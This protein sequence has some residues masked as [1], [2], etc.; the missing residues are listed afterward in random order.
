MKKL[1]LSVAAILW[2]SVMAPAVL[3]G[4][5]VTVVAASSEAAE[6]LDLHAVAELFKDSENLEDFERQL[7]DPDTGINNL[8][9]DND[10]EID[11]IRVLETVKNSSHLIVL[12]VPMGDNE[13][14]DVATIEVARDGEDYHLVIRGCDVIY[15]PDYYYIPAEAHFQLWPIIVWIYRPLY[16]PYWS[17]WYWHHY[18]GWW[19]PYHPIAYRDYRTRVVRY[20]ERRTFVL[21]RTPGMTAVGGVTY[22]PQNSTLVKKRTAAAVIN[23]DRRE[24]RRTEVRGST[25]DHRISRSHSSTL[26][27][28]TSTS[29]NTEPPKEKWVHRGTTTQPGRTT[30]G[31]KSSSTMRKPATAN[32]GTLSKSKRSTDTFKS[33]IKTGNKDGNR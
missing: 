20:S 14:Q 26:E 23:E 31:D 33:T 19:N 29:N 27:H 17:S 24:V 4:Q 16:H 9:L 7:N 22:R 25:P 6:G 32:K 15:G 21:T 10:G 5:D 3:A 12:Q 18:P 30:S 11:F 13:F 28:R 2:L 8:D 1:F